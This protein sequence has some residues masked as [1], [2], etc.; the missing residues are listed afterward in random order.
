MELSFRQEEKTYFADSRRKRSNGKKRGMHLAAWACAWRRIAPLQRR[1]N[2]LSRESCFLTEDDH[3]ATMR[4]YVAVWSV[5]AF[6]LVLQAYSVLV[7]ERHVAYI[8]GLIQT[9]TETKGNWYNSMA[10]MTC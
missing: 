10:S 6:A 7:P 5:I 9:F 1:E 3:I 4:V 8:R 2:I